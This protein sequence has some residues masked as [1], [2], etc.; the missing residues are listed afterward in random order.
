MPVLS[1]FILNEIEVVKWE[2]NHFYLAIP[3]FVFLR[4]SG[5][6]LPLIQCFVKLLDQTKHLGY[7]WT[8]NIGIKDA[9]L[10][11]FKGK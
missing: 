2:E 4:H 9:D 5:K 7:A 1:E 10:I 6:Y 11:A 3:V 8:R